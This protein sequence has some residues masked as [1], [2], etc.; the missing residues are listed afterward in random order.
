VE[1]NETLKIRKWTKEE[2]IRIS[3]WKRRKIISWE[4]SKQGGKYQD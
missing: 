4:K 3:M 1:K 2:I